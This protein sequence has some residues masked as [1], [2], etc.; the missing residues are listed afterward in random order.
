M[1]FAIPE[2]CCPR[3]V[4]GDRRIKGD[5]VFRRDEVSRLEKLL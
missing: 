5:L 3:E 4:I 1:T 2:P